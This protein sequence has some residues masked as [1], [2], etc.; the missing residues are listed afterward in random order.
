MSLFRYRSSYPCKS[1]SFLDSRS[2]GLFNLSIYELTLGVCC[3]S[4]E[5]PNQNSGKWGFYF[6]PPSSHPKKQDSR[7][8]R[9]GPDSP[10]SQSWLCHC[11]AGWPCAGQILQSWFSLRSMW[12]NIPPKMVVSQTTKEV[13]MQ[14]L[15]LPNTLLRGRCSA[16]AESETWVSGKTINTT[17][18]TT[19]LP[20]YTPGWQAATNVK[21]M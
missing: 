17:S 10:R 14:E 16:L 4:T 13:Y 18:F 1:R 2:P 7:R 5:P 15:I 21:L 8:N 11:L 9:P 6:L 20:S 19:V 3:Q 12:S